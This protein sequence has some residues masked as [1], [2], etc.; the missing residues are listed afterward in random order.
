MRSK[1]TGKSPGIVGGVFLNTQQSRAGIAVKMV[2]L[3]IKLIISEGVRCLRLRRESGLPADESRLL[4][5]RVQ[6]VD[7]HEGSAHVAAGNRLE[8]GAGFA[9]GSL[10]ALNQVAK[11]EVMLQVELH[12]AF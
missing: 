1:M 3:P 10:Q 8:L 7:L 6:G 5:A 12:C 11:I 9:A 4:R 2:I